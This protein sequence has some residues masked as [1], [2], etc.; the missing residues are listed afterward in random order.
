MT[1]VLAFDVGTTAMKCCAFDENFHLRA[2]AST[3]Y[4]LTTRGEH[5]IEVDPSLYWEGMRSSLQQIFAQGV[6]PSE[7]AAV[8]LTTQG[9]TMIPV[10]AS[11]KPLHPAIVWLDTR[12][13]KEAEALRSEFGEDYLYRTTGLSGLSGAAP[14]AK[15]KWLMESSGLKKDIAKILLLEDFL[16]YRLTGEMVGEQSLVCSTMYYDIVK[17]AYDKDIVRATGCPEGVLPDILPC[18]TVAGKVTEAAAAATGL[19]P[20]TPVVMTAMDQTASAIGAGNVETGM[21][22]ETTGTCLTVMLTLDKAEFDGPVPLQYY[23]HYDGR[24]LTLAYAS[25]AAAIMKWYKDQF[26]LDSDAFRQSDENV[27]QYMS[28]LAAGV[29]PGSDGLFLIPHYAGKSMPQFSPDLRGCFYGVGLHTTK[30]HFIRAI[31]EGI[32]Y[33]LQENLD[34]YRQA[35]FEVKKIRSLGGGSKDLL[36][37]Q[38]KAD[39]TGCEIRTVEADETTSLGAAVLAAVAVGIA[40]DVPT[41][42]R[43]IVTEKD[44]YLPR[45]EISRKYAGLYREYLRLDAAARSFADGQKTF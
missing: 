30:A 18:G 7:I 8:G 5:I 23:T 34:T 27:Y 28:R 42:C 3:E 21:I 33:N 38:I 17:R 6:S 24:F 16:V 12:A 14:A 25:T 1:T 26:I 41:L 10:D 2:S 9:E 35:G 31:E 36:W 22:S 15:L 43:K 20:G 13:D 37:N 32:A 11:G 45:P 39:I 40:S 19:L 44:I 4:Q 29:A